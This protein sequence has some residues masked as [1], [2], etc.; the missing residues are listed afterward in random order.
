VKKAKAKAKPVK[1]KAKPVQ[2][3][4]IDEEEAEDDGATN[5]PSAAPE[6]RYNPELL[7]K[8]DNTRDESMSGFVGEKVVKRSDHARSVPKRYALAFNFVD[9][10][11][12]FKKAYE[13]ET[14]FGRRWIFRVEIVG[15]DPK[16]HDLTIMRPDGNYETSWFAPTFKVSKCGA[17]EKVYRGKHVD[18]C[19]CGS[20]NVKKFWECRTA[21]DFKK[22]T[23]ATGWDQ[24]RWREFTYRMS[25]TQTDRGYDRF[26]IDLLEGPSNAAKPAKKPHS[27]L[28]KNDDD[29]WDANV[30]EK[31]EASLVPVVQKMAKKGDKPTVEDWVATL[32]SDEIGVK[33]EAEA[34]ALWEHRLELKGWPKGV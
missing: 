17:C 3:K 11:F 7:L 22:V 2:K 28:K 30:R 25:V 6:Q 5:A 23:E 1:R 27:L 18:E 15:A 32:V 8:F 4:V 24:Q 10:H 16:K 12:P 14:Q 29:H 20:K 21:D 26:N 33:T 9:V 19:D 34:E 13:R 31:V